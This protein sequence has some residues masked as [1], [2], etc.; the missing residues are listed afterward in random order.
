MNDFDNDELVAAF[1]NIVTTYHDQI[2]PYAVDI[3]KHLAKQYMRLINQETNG[4]NECDALLTALGSYTSM[5]RILDVV[6][7]DPNLLC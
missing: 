1:E 7:D 3:I 5:S 4:D 6:K 2:A